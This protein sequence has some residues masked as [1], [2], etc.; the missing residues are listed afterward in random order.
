VG[1]V[2]IKPG[3]GLTRLSLSF[4]LLFSRLPLFHFLIFSFLSHSLPHGNLMARTKAT[5]AKD[6]ALSPAP[7]V[8]GAA[9]HS[10]PVV[11]VFGST[12]CLSLS[13]PRLFSSFSLSASLFSLPLGFSWFGPRPP[14]PRTLFSHSALSGELGVVI[15]WVNPCRGSWVL[16][17]NQ[18]HGGLG[19]VE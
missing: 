13:L 4:S 16:C 7:C 14:W 6:L 12:F 3:S 5:M 8:A 1:R 9:H 2:S 17:E 10:P 19:F 18:D 11:E 15:F